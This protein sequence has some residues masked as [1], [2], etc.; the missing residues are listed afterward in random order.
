MPTGIYDRSLCL[1]RKKQNNYERFWNKI[2]RT[3]SCW[4]WTPLVTTRGYGA[5]WYNG[6]FK[7]AHRFAYEQIAGDIPRGKQL[8]HICRVR[9][10]VNPSHLEVVTGKENVL[11]GIGP[12]AINARKSRCVRGHEFSGV[13]TW[14]FR[15]CNKCKAIT[16][17]IRYRLRKLQGA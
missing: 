1:D 13:G 16:A 2:D 9:R 15:V 11:R 17:R 4:L 8:D 7:S 5:F 6:R 12:T 10:C 3:P 14:G